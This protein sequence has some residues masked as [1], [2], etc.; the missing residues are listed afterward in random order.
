MNPTLNILSVQSSARGQDSTSRA[1][2]RQ[3][4]D[5]LAADGSTHVVEQNAAAATPLIDAAW[6][7][8]TFTDPNARDDDDRAALAYSD[9]LVAQLEAADLIV[10]GVP[11]YNFGVPAALK[12]WFDQVARA[13]RTFRYTAEGPQ[14]LLN[15]KR[16]VVIVSSGGVPVDSPVDFATPHV[17]QFLKFLGIDD[18]TVIAADQLNQN[19]DTAMAKANAQLL[20]VVERIGTA[21]STSEVA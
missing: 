12:A 18:I 20:E 1:L 21:R 6:V 14:G 16:A 13:G 2:T 11:I 17:R 10:L 3:L 8:A 9:A 19:A 15:G 7:K 5:A 4:T